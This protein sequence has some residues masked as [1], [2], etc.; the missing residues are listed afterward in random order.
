MSTKTLAD[1]RHNDH[2]AYYATKHSAPVKRKVTSTGGGIMLE[3]TGPNPEFDTKTGRKKPYTPGNTSRIEA[4]T[5]E[6]A[7]YWKRHDEL[8]ELH[9]RIDRASPE[10]VTAMLEEYPA[11]REH[12]VQLNNNDRMKLLEWMKSPNGSHRIGRVNFE[13][14][15]GGGLLVRTDPY[16]VEYIELR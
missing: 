10:R 2:V 16:G 3:A 8:I 6:I 9:R 4:I 1:I 7:A 14:V 11:Q 15:E 5:P 12:I 13:A